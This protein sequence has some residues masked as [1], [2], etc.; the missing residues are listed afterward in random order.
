LGGGRV[1]LQGHEIDSP[2]LAAVLGRVTCLDSTEELALI[3][4]HVGCDISKPPL[5]KLLKSFNLPSSLPATRDSGKE[6]LIGNRG[7]GVVGLF[8]NSSLG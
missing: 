5:V 2:S 3:E 4:G 7:I 8:R 6:R 1:G